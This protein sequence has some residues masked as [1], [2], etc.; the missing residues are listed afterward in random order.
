MRVVIL[1]THSIRRR[2]LVREVQKFA[3]VERVFV[4]T[5]GSRAPFETDHPFEAKSKPHE[6]TAWFNGA[7]PAF[8]DLANVEYFQSLN[9]ADAVAA[10]RAARPDM[11]IVFGTGKLSTNIISICPRGCVNL[12]G[13]NPEEYRGLDASLWAIYHGDFQQL[14]TTVQVLAAELDCGDIVARRATPLT[15]GMGLHKL[16]RAGTEAAIPALREAIEGFV[17]NGA[18]TGRHMARKGRYYSHMP[19]VLKENC[20][21]RF[22]RHTAQLRK[23]A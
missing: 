5:R 22:E 7:P 14:M 20:L 12:H 4:E 21:K 18:V 8:S 19:A 17:T 11:I 1:T 10:I 15:R 3:T 13:G 2:F 6:I 23:T 16:R 9:S